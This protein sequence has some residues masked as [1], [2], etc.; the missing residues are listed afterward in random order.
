MLEVTLKL[1][2]QL[3][4]NESYRVSETYEKIIQIIESLKYSDDCEVHVSIANYSENTTE[5]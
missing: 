2:R 5:D 3:A 4:T 1:K